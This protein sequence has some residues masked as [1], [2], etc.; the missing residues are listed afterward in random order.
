M[1]RP[2]IEEHEKSLV[3]KAERLGIVDAVNTEYQ[4][5]VSQYNGGGE[6]SRWHKL[7]RSE[8]K[9]I[10]RL[11]SLDE[12]EQTVRLYLGLDCN[13]EFVDQIEFRRSFTSFFT[14]AWYWVVTL[15]PP[16][17]QKTT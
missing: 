14:D 5:A 7:T 8:R 9:A 1:N 16:P 13:K 4:A 6:L 11:C 17:R 3:A 10:K 12:Y 2:S 15:A